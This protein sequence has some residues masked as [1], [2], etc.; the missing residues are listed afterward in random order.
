M[1]DDVY[2]DI[3]FFVFCYL[4]CYLFEEVDWMIMFE[5]ELWMIVFNL[6][7]VDEEWKRYEFV[8]LNVKV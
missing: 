1:S 8:Y 3:V 7:E 4:G 5:F 6:V 2:Y